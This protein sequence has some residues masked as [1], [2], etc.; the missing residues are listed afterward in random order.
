MVN[1]SPTLT[2]VVDNV[3]DDDT[4][5]DDELVTAADMAQVSLPFSRFVVAEQSPPVYSNVSTEG[6]HSEGDEHDVT[7]VVEPPPVVVPGVV[8]CA[9]EAWWVDP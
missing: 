4:V 9:V 2:V 5:T 3:A 8:P 1:M 7:L 6:W